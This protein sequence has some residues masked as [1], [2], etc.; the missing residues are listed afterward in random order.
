VVD[1]SS[2]SA[3]EQCQVVEEILC[4]LDIVDKPLITVLNKIDRLPGVDKNLAEEEAL[5]YLAEKDG[6]ASEN[7]VLISATMGWGLQNLLET[8]IIA[9]KSIKKSFFKTS[10]KN[11]TL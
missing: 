10:P 1:L 7:T 8:I 4:D 2:S 11:G 3:A 6:T 5:N 9:M